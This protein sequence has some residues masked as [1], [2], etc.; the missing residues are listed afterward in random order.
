MKIH[1]WLIVIQPFSHMR[2]LDNKRS[3]EVEKHWP[4][5]RGVTD[6]HHEELDMGH[7]M[8]ISD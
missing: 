7:L 6:K 4:L 8:M 1:T 2:R 5:D 3:A